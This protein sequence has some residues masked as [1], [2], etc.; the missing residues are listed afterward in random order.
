[1]LNFIKILVSCLV[2]SFAMHAEAGTFESRK[3]TVD[4]KGGKI[5]FVVPKG[6]ENSLAPGGN[7]FWIYFRYPSMTPIKPCEN[8]Q[9][10]AVSLLVR[11]GNS[12]TPS[13]SEMTLDDLRVQ[14]KNAMAVHL[15]VVDGFDTFSAID[16]TGQKKFTYFSKQP[17]GELICFE[18]VLSKIS[19]SRAYDKEIEL[20]Y[21]FSRTLSAKKMD[22]DQKVVALIG[23]MINGEIK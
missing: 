16:A 9:P 20:K 2:T 3:I 12:A 23:H 22:V 14:S 19:A 11:A 5:T 10:D 4:V 7:G 17:K 15:G 6:Y 8:Q 1:M 13:I 18:E 21:I